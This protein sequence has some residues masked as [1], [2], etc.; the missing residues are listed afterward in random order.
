VRPRHAASA[1][2]LLA[3]ACRGDL[4]TQMSPPDLPAYK[5]DV[6]ASKH[7]LVLLLRTPSAEAGA[8]GGQTVDLDASV[9]NPQGHVLDH[10]KHTEWRSTDEAIATVDSTG[11][12]T[13]QDT[14]DVLIIVDEKKAA[15]TVR[16]RIIPVPVRSVVVAGPDSIGVRDTVAYVATA[17][18]SAGEALVSREVGWHSTDGTVLKMLGRGSAEAL[19]EGSAQVEATVDA[20]TG[21]A[22]VRVWPA[23]VATSRCGRR[24][25]ACRSFAR[26]ASPWRRETAMASCSPAAR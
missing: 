19:A 12:I 14:G 8:R 22:P 17:L 25:S 18:D 20:V 16:V 24:R 21:R 2:L 7:D 13:A 6:T 5:V 10:K 4:A 9:T 11:L 23:T 3:A 26:L 1:L 15:D